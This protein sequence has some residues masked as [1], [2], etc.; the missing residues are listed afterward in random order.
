LT[1]LDGVGAH[2]TAAGAAQPPVRRCSA[3]W[4]G[5]A[6]P[7]SAEEVNWPETVEGDH[8]RKCRKRRKKICSRFPFVPSEALCD[9]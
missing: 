4:R 6:P 7:H 9:S 8:P 3:T 2:L 5:N 1:S